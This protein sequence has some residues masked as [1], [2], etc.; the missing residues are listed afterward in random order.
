MINFLAEY[1]ALWIIA[2]ALIGLL[3][4][5]FGRN[6]SKKITESD[7]NNNESL[8]SDQLNQSNKYQYVPNS[9]LFPGLSWAE[10]Q[11]LL[12]IE[13]AKQ[14]DWM[15]GELEFHHQPESHQMRANPDN[16]MTLG[17]L[18]SI[19]DISKNEIGDMYVVS[20]Y[21]KM[22]GQ[23]IQNIEKVWNF[24]LCS[25]ILVE[26]NGEIST[27]FAE[28]VILNIWYKRQKNE[29][30][31]DELYKHEKYK[32]TFDLII[33]HLRD[34]GIHTCGSTGKENYYICATVCI[35]PFAYTKQKMA[36]TEYDRLQGK[37]VSITFAYDKRSSEQKLAEYRYILDDA[38]DKIK[39]NRANELS[40]IQRFFV[41]NVREDIGKDFYFGKKSLEGNSYGTAIEYF[42]NVYEY[43]NSEWLKQELSNEEKYYFFESC[44]C[45]GFCFSELRLYEKALYYLDIVW[46]IDNID[47]KEEY[48][49]CL[50][51]KNDFRAL[52]IVSSEIN[53]ISEIRRYTTELIDKYEHYYQFLFRRIVYIYIESGKLDEAEKILK[54]MLEKSPDEDFILSELAYIQYIRNQQE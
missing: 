14:R 36:V 23:L 33:V 53:R 40:D 1:N 34:S 19:F 22:Q 50:V 12:E 48:I 41:D 46:Y 8:S 6:K 21:R 32:G 5:I 7:I 11:D 45:L 13:T 42:M 2:V 43:L 24:D 25:A 52:Q 38:I 39:N 16:N 26:H 27:K 49:N 35:P 17:R 20:N 29:S 28:H 47:Y 4:F 30:E 18:L 9:N 51:N 44:S 10:N 31:T 54:D 37:V 3:F 15:R